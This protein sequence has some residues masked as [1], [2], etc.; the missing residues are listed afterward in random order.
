[1]TTAITIL[2]LIFWGVALWATRF[3]K[4][5]RLQEITEAYLYLSPAAVLLAVFWFIPVIF[6]IIVSFTDWSQLGDSLSTV[7]WVGAKNYVRAV[8]DD[9]FMVVLYNTI[10]YVV[11]SVPLTVA[12]ALFVA[13]LMNAKLR[14]KGAFRTIYFLPYITTW[15]AISIVFK[16]VFNE[17]FGL[18]NYYLERMGIPALGWLSESRGIIE[19]LLRDG[20]GVPLPQ[21]MHPLLA[22]PSLAMFT[23]I[24]TSV[25]R[26][27]GYFMVI[28]LAGLQNIDRSYYEAAEID[29]ASIRQQ[30]RHVTWP[31]L[32]PTTFF[33]LII[34][35]IT[36]FK[37]FV[38]MFI[39]T[40]TGGPART[41]ETLVFFLYK[42]GFMGYRELGYAAAIAYILFAIILVLTLV[43]NR[44]IGKKVHYD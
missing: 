16:Y 22:G 26:D 18:A 21:H 2:L 13:M 20:L 5:K 10:N 1:M 12:V 35:M 25:W 14:A 38:P 8:Q 41:T 15:V 31:L 36:A 42:I 29:G 6:S 28:F 44:I 11:Y 39:M 43:Q 37:V 30:F 17:H 23:I 34:S 33:V 4:N 32:S 24:I 7:D 19:L 9:D 3:I 40:P 27:T